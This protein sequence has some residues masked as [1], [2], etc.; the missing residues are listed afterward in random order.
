[1]NHKDSIGANTV[2]KKRLINLIRNL[3]Y[4]I[5]F[6]LW[7]KIGGYSEIIEINQILFWAKRQDG[8]TAI[9]I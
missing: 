8:K 6:H 2:S 9:A 3:E 5:S 7:N 4:F 1:M